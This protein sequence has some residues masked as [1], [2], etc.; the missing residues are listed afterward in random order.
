MNCCNFAVVD[1]RNEKENVS[2]NGKV[3]CSKCNVDYLSKIR[4]HQLLF[5]VFT[6]DKILRHLFQS[7]S[8]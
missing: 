3:N 1:N 5:S 4:I 7:D 8:L 6:P 2:M